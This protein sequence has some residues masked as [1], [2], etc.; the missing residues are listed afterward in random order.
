MISDDRLQK[1]MTYLAETDEELAQ[2]KANV[3]RAE[4]LKKRV[5]A[6]GFLSA[7]GKSVEERKAQS[8][9][10]QEVEDV[11]HDYTRA[12]VAYEHIAAKRKT[13]SL[14]V[15]VWRSI[16]ANRRQG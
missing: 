4:Y 6:A 7:P 5:R 8:E 3:E 12:L 16:N 15:E 1:A 14:I 9:V 13:E 10:S 11:E 2:L